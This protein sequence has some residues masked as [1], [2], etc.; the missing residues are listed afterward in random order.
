MGTCPVFPSPQWNRWP[1]SGSAVTRGWRG[2]SSH[3]T[4]GTAFTGRGLCSELRF[5]CVLGLCPAV[6]WRACGP[7]SP[8]QGSRPT[9]GDPDKATLH[10]RGSSSATF[11]TA[12]GEVPVSGILLPFPY[13]VCWMYKKS[14]SLRIQNFF[15]RGA[16]RKLPVN[17]D[18]LDW[19]QNRNLEAIAEHGKIKWLLF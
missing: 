1:E 3:S 2:T 19:I 18:C 10:S 9:R 11:T 5:R 8:P 12:R 16:V 15:R 6:L 7:H 14:L 4:R 17:K 13:R